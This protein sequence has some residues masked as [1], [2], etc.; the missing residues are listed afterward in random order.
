[1]YKL[2]SIKTQFSRKQRGFGALEV[3]IGLMI[4]TLVLIGA[5]VW[6][7]KLSNSSNNGDELENLSSLITSVRHLKTSSGYGANGTNLVPILNNAGGIPDNMGF[8]AGVPLNAWGGN[9]TIVSTGLGFTVTYAGLPAENCIFLATKGAS[10]STMTTRINGGAAITG[11]VTAAAANTGC[12]AAT[13]T[14]AWT[15]R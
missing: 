3:M 10:S 12:N 8:N 1:M 5:V 15:A 11:E 7:Q 4:G 14:L 2:S 6:Y 9:V 13:N